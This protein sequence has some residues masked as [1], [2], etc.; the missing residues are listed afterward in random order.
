MPQ[1]PERRG[2][3]T[4]LVVWVGQVVSALGSNLTGFALGV[5]IYQQTGSVTR[6][7]LIALV[8]TL[9]G[10]LL[11]PLAGALVDRWDRRCAMILSDAGA[12]SM[13]LVLAALLWSDRLELWH[14]YLL[15]AASSVF[16]TL[17]WPAFTAA[18][19]L[20]VPREHLG[21]ASGLTQL[22]NGIAEI[23][24]PA[25]AGALVVSIGLDGVVLIDAATFLVA[26]STLLA[27][28]VP[29]APVSAEGAAVRGSL[30]RET[31]AGWSY[32]RQRTGLL[33]LLA[34]LATTNFSMGILQVLVTPMVLSFTSP[35]VL[36][37]VLT[38]A[39]L[40]MLAGSLVMSVWG[41][42]RRR[43]AG[44]LFFLLLQGLSLMAGGLRPSA[45]LIAAVGIVFL[46]STP[47]ILGC[48]QALWQSKVP[49]DLQGRVFAVRRMVAWS[50]LP[51][52]YLVAGPLA[53][54]VFE[55][56]LAPGGPLAG[57]V[58]RWIGVGEGRGIA[59]LFIFLGV[60]VVLTVAVA[61]RHP[62]L[63]RI[64][65]EL[66]DVL[67][68]AAPAAVPDQKP[69]SISP[70]E[71]SMATNSH[72]V[73]PAEATTP[74]PQPG[75]RG[76]RPAGRG[77]RFLRRVALGLVL[78]IGLVL[79]IVAAGG[80]WLRSRMAA[81]LP[82]LAGERAVA[83]L[84]APVVVERD[85]LGVPTIRAAGRLDA[86]RATGFVHA[87]DRTFQMDLLRRRAAGELAELLGGGVVEVD[88]GIRVHRMRAVARVGVER[89]P[90]DQRALLEAYAEG[91]NAGRAALG[92]KPFEYLLL[93]T[94]PAPWLPEDSLLV[95]LAMYLDL[96]EP[97]FVRESHLG[98]LHD[99]LPRPLFELLGP[100]GSEWDA[101]MEGE[102]LRVPDIPGP[103]VWSVESLPKA[104][105]LGPPRHPRPFG[106]AREPE[107][108]R[109]SNAWAVDGERSADGGALLANDTHLDQGVP[110]IWYRLSLAWPAEGGGERRVTGA[111]L[112][113]LPLVVVGS[114]GRVAWG[115]TNSQID[116]SD[117]VVVEVDPADADRY[118]TPQGPRRFERHREVI[119]TSGG[120]GEAFEVVSTIW[121][122]VVGKD[123][124]GRPRALRWV[125]H[126]PEALDLGLAG[127]ET[128]E[129]LEEAIDVANRSGAPVQ[130]LVLADAS[131]GVAWTLVGSLPRRVGFDGRLPGSW[132]D[133]TR[134]WHGLLPPAEYPRIV[135]PPSGRIW[136]ANNRTL[137]GE[138]LAALGD[139]NYVFGARPRQ[140]RD[141]L[142]ELERATPRDM[143]ALQLDDRALFL[144]R[145]RELLLRTLTPEALGADPR[146]REY[147]RLIEAWEG[148][149]AV[150]AVGYRLV[151][152]VRSRL[153]REVF[154]P[155]TAACKEAD[156]E[157]EYRDATEQAEVALWKLVSEQPPHLLDPAYRS[158]P[159]RL[160]AAVDAVIAQ[161]AEEGVP[162]SG[163]T[164][165]RANP[166]GIQHPLSLALPFLGRWLDMPD[167]PLPGDFNMPL[168]QRPGFGPS[169]RMVVSPGR[170]EAGFF[171]MPGGQSGH[172]LSP[173]YR[174][175]HAAWAEGRPTP[176]LPGPTVHALKLVPVARAP[177]A[178]R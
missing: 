36:G 35:A 151:R 127:L 155:L 145:W 22:G 63:R 138:R 107:A 97:A 28:R 18:T 125:A 149:A 167:Q 51:L 158:W 108:V 118:L 20:L 103:E 29:R 109:G 146:R 153:L 23:L 55:P 112:P 137:S 76:P 16:A 121:G 69:G 15:L 123:H 38:V 132:A 126:E 34:L 120:E 133:G 152:E 91:V 135:S 140:I 156:P 54:R 74:E 168:L 101:P 170:E 159:E 9:P 52:A 119:R 65:S 141:R 96:Q 26:V 21:R 95:I 93:R 150:D 31:L 102:P 11:S 3:A 161:S 157:F 169:M 110:N 84:S 24:A 62:R 60:F 139:A 8:T 128:A 105:A 6:F 89:L 90:P 59:L 56:L 154:V 131:G 79:A 82:E 178:R 12:G 13:T 175:G 144:A 111:S 104:A 143:L 43:V 114:N 42:P 71:R 17:Q 106:R 162:L 80:V 124:R 130:N 163:M 142:F 98:L 147:R 67:P 116:T 171:H 117:L 173:H 33:V 75:R 14:I 134:R 166:A 99:L 160:L 87:Q 165:G 45:T 48:S 113:G 73:P 83:G 174:D 4:F 94:D 85:A 5:W 61:A 27:I 37:R 7:A 86:A 172:P 115:L 68:D 129:T 10:T 1:R 176:F 122:P 148:R 39:G 41:G 32:I 78:V 66:P 57:S 88:R 72:S 47:M 40:G 30:W 46:F 136:S 2:I 81:G 44:I 177:H 25:L 19:T 53:D 58:G 70:Q 50:T 100:A 164:W 49:P 77:R 92:E 64:E